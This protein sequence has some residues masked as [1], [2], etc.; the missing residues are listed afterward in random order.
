MQGDVLVAMARDILE[1]I[2]TEADSLDLSL[3]DRQYVTLGG[4]VFDC[5]QV[6]VAAMSAN[7]GVVS[8]TGE[9]LD[10][11]GNCPPVWSA[12]FEA[13]IVLCANE[14]MG[15]PR[16]QLLPLVSAVEE[17]AAKMSLAAAVLINVAE[18]MTDSFGP[19][20]CTIELGQPQGGLVA[21][22]AT[23]TTNLWK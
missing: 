11:I 15:G 13:A 17:D 10:V 6:S 2:G 7:T 18:G 23:I 14:K 22:V 5:E 9:G 16:G 20:R 4:A 19:V 21:A 3:P 8:A 12:P 1:R